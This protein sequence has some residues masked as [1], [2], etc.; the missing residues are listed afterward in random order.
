MTRETPRD[1]GMTLIE[2]VVA[3]VVLGILAAATLTVILKAQEGSADNRSRVAAANLAAREIEMVRAQFGASKAGPRA[4][5]DAGTVTNPHPLSDGVA[6][7]PLTL[8]GTAYTVV[9]SVAWNIVGNGASACDGGSL[10][11]YPSLNVTVTVTWPDMH[12]VA[13]V[14]SS[15]TMAPEKG[16]GVQTGAAFVAVNVV[17]SDGEPNAGRS[18]RVSGAGTARTAVTDSSGCAVVEVTP[19]V[20]GTDY[21][22]QMIDSGYV[23]I[24]R[25]A[26][27]SKPVGKVMPGALNNSVSF[28]YDRAASLRLRFVD[29]AGTPV[30]GGSLG[31]SSVTLV[32]SEFSGPNGRSEWPVTGTVTSVVGLWPTQYGAYFGTTAPSEY[33]SA[34]LEAGATVD[35]DVLVGAATSAIAGLPAGTTE[36]VAVPASATTCTGL[37]NRVVDPAGFTVLP[38][39]W[40]FYATGAAFLCSPGPSAVALDDGANDGISWS[41]TTLRVNNAPAGSLWGVSRSRVGG[42]TITTC[43][44]PGYAGVAV[45]LD[46]ARNGPLAIPAGDWFVYV[47]TGGAGDTC[48]STPGSQYSMQLPYGAATTLTWPAQTTKLSVTSLRSSSTVVLSKTSLAGNNCRTSG[49]VRLGPTGSQ[50]TSS[51]LSTTVSR[52]AAG[53]QTWYA[54]VLRSNT[55][56]SIGTFVVGTASTDLSKAATATGPVGP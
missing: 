19:G 29:S 16:E 20:A 18:V 8:D 47:T 52:P 50:S 5:A 14:V 56:T 31:S 13:P 44:G 42:A 23:D 41:T 38:G 35:L 46:A 32:A 30:D 11:K 33:R 22:A 4:V 2:V 15:T 1:R 39:S 28:A 55:C 54:Y 7:Q 37:G 27:P 36:V 53:T 9:R 21:T 26:Q 6:G 10:V 40:T 25:A 43:P 24:S 3:M 17:D 48:V 34:D 51:T 45:P 49:D 12:G